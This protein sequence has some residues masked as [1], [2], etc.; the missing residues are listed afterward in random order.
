MYR[1][2][3]QFSS[4]QEGRR[5]SHPWEQHPVSPCR[6]V[7]RAHSQARHRNP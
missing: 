4:M 3:P 6:R 1:N 7:T 2:A 5:H